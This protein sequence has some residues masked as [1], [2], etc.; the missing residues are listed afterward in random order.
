M[1]QPPPHASRHN[2]RLHHRQ[3]RRHWAATWWRGNTGTEHGQPVTMRR[4]IVGQFERM[5]RTTTPLRLS[6]CALPVARH[7]PPTAPQEDDTRQGVRTASHIASRQRHNTA[8]QDL[9]RRRER[10]TDTAAARHRILRHWRH[11]YDRSNARQE[12]SAATFNPGKADRI[13]RRGN[14]LRTAC[15]PC[16][17]R[18][19]GS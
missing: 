8:Q 11:L 12:R 7:W 5:T 4:A 6:A 19:A 15:G 13:G 3:R 14:P 1:R 2:H 9:R 17:S 10:Q 18:R 16:I